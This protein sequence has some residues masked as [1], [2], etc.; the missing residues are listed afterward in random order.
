MTTETPARRTQIEDAA[1]A[2]FRERGYQATSIRD[3]AQVLNIQGPSLYAHVSSKEDVLW[4]IVKRA[5]DRF[6]AEV[7][8]LAAANARASVRLRDMI[9]GH[10]AVVTQSQ[11]D[12]AVFLHEW[13][14]LSADRRAD[15]AAR[16]DT[17]ERLFRDV[18]ADGAAK[19][20][21]AAVDPKL[22]AMA[23]LSALNGIATWFSPTGDHTAS[24][25]A[26]QYADLFIRGLREDH[27]MSRAFG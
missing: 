12:A 4:S 27:F 9:R 2:L 1:S 3:I 8:P 13:R 26:D 14:F 18:I 22:T 5:A 24:E 7:G 17:Y 19:G 21:F 6:N 20:E 23:I 16:R 15:I 11:R 10:V 25:I